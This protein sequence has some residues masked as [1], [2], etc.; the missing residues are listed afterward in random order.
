VVRPKVLHQ[1]RHPQVGDCGVERV[2]R[3]D[4]PGLAL[5]GDVG[6]VLERLEPDRDV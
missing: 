4:P 2:E 1:D 3:V 5:D 6:V